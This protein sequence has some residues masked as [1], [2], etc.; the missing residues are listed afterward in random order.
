[1][2]SKQLSGD[3][4]SNMFIKAFETLPN[5]FVT[6]DYQA[7]EEWCIVQTMGAEMDR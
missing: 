5:G 6:N 4:L 1:M 2:F 3:T 7:I